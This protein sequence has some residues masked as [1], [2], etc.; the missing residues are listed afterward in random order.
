MT[1]ALRQRE[2]SGRKVRMGLTVGGISFRIELTEQMSRKERKMSIYDTLN[3][4]QRE[5]VLQT[6]GP[7]LILAGAG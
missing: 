6:E 2:H 5:A 4:K 3:D 1:G 7:V